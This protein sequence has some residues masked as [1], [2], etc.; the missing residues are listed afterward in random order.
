[1]RNNKVL[2]RSLVLVTGMIYGLQLH[3]QD[4][5]STPLS[6]PVYH[7]MV[8]NPAY[9]G[10]K[11][12]TNFSL[13]SKVLK[14]P[15]YQLLNYHQRLSSQDGSFSSFGIGIYAFQEQLDQS[16]N[17]GL[18]V[19]GSFHLALDD[20]HIHNI[21]AGL[22]AKGIMMVPKTGEESPSDS[23]EMVFRPNLD[24]GIYYYGPTGFVGLSSTTL[25]GTTSSGDS[26]TD[27]YSMID[28]E[29]HLYGGYKFLVSKRLGIVIEPSLLV[30]L[31]DSSISEPHKHLVPYL[32]IY[33]QNLYVGTYLKD[34]DI[35]A[36]FFQYQFPK[37]YT[38]VF[39]EFPRIGYL[40]DENII[41][42][43]TVGVNLAKGGNSFRQ[44]RHW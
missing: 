36:L 39:L 31:N 40:N 2:L 10:S 42:E 34:L 7:L 38:G 23:S 20:H 9:V 1:M 15:D 41:F 25:M 16:W 5:P 29:Y 37:F 12:F 17:S 32:K 35:I 18:A 4:V 26:L 14:S 43:V 33:L 28:R 21:A 3:G 13:T 6:I 30:S 22:T 19:A 27:S 44:Y 8:I 11:D 24:L